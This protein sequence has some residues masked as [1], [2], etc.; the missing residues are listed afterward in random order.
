MA[1]IEHVPFHVDTI[2]AAIDA[3]E[4]AWSVFQVAPDGEPSLRAE[5]AHD[6]ARGALLGTACATRFGALALLRHLRWWLAE[7]AAFA[8][9][10]QPDY[11][12][13]QARFADLTLFLG[14]ELPPATIP[15]AL[16]MGRL[17]AGIVRR[18]STSPSLY[19]RPA[20][21]LP[22]DED[23][24]GSIEPWQAVAPI[25][26]DTAHVRALRCLDGMGETLAALTIV[27]FGMA[28]IG[29][30]TLA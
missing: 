30:A 25:R 13:A 9:T 14:Y 27:I 11:G 15:T 26:P 5:E 1:T 16:P 20:P 4:E 28:A 29:L 19:G 17:S 7:E 8:E 18:L 10:Y 12:V 2:L 6:A 21:L 3:H 22:D 23:A 24:P